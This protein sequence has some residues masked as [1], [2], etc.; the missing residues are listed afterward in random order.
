MVLLASVLYFSSL[1]VSTLIILTEAMLPFLWL[2]LA[3]EKKIPILIIRARGREQSGD[4]LLDTLQNYEAY[5]VLCV[6]DAAL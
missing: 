1:C 5:L 4:R 6:R 3:C 2:I